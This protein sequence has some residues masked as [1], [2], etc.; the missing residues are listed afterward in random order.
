MKPAFLN[1][2]LSRLEKIVVFYF[3]AGS[4]EM[5]LSVRFRLKLMKK[6]T[7]RRK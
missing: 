7:L 4:V 2:K 6:T 5:V 1:E 3:C